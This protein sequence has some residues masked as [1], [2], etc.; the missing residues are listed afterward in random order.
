MFVWF[1]YQG[2]TTDLVGL[3]QNHLCPSELD[4][5]TGSIFEKCNDN[6]I[7]KTQRATSYW[8]KERRKYMSILTVTEKI[9]DKMQ[10]PFM[11]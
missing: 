1:W 2:I 3:K 6:S 10:H 8:Q 7:F 11:S 4:C 9:F 5:Q